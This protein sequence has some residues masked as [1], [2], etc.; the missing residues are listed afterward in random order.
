[1]KVKKTNLKSGI[2]KA[3]YQGGLVLNVG[4]EL[5]LVNS[6]IQIGE[7]N[8]REYGYLEFDKGRV[9]LSKFGATSTRVKEWTDGS[10]EGA[11]VFPNTGEEDNL[12]ALV[13]F[14]NGNNGKI[15]VVAKGEGNFGDV[16]AFA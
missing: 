9:S 5:K 4:D 10:P 2:V 7:F 15:K 8:G 1:M 11:F 3:N 6:E 14:I 13:D 12:D 16:Y